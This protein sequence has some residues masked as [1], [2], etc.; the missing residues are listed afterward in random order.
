MQ[1]NFYLTGN[2]GI[3][4]RVNGELDHHGAQQIRDELDERII[5]RGIKNLVFDF[6][7]LSFMDSSGIGLIIGR[8]K[9]IKSLGGNVSIVC[10]NAC[11]NKILQMSGIM[12]II[13]VHTDNQY[14]KGLYNE[15]KVTKYE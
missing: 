2:N 9:L 14:L 1:V 8:Y 6:D 15:R 10:S 5:R 4:V 11:V 3:S 12:R 13:D 7:D